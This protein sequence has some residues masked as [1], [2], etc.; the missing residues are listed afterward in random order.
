M[1]FISRD[2]SGD[3]MWCELDVNIGVY[4]RAA[5]DFLWVQ[6]QSVWF[7]SSTFPK[8]QSATSLYFQ[9]EK[10]ETIDASHQEWLSSL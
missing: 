2:L 1:T 9:K 5:A 3:E 4:L 8:L 7:E 10:L 6:M